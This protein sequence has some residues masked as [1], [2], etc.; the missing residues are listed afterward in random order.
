M[1]RQKTQKKPFCVWTLD[2]DPDCGKWDTSCGEA[3]C[4]I[5]DGPAENNHRFCPYC[6]DRLKIARESR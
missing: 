1:S 5:T 4:F 6:G 2:D 3:H